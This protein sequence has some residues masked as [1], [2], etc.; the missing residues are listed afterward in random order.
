MANHNNGWVTV[1]KNLKAV[2]SDFRW[3][4]QQIANTPINVAQIVPSLPEL[5]GYMDSCKY[6]AGGVWILPT[7][8]KT[9][10]FIVWTVNFTP[11]IIKKFNTHEITINDLELAG[12]LLGWLVLEHLL[13]SLHH[14]QIGIKCDNSATVAWAR[15]FSAR[16]LRAGHLLC[17]LALRQQICSSSPLLVVHTPGVQNDMA[18]VASCFASTPKLTKASPNLLT[19]FNTHFKQKNSW[20]IF[21]LPTKLTSLVMSLLLDMQLSLESWRRLPGLVKSTGATGAVTQRA[22]TSTRYCRAPTLSSETL[23][24]QH[25]LQGSGVV[26]TAEDIRSEFKASLM[27]YRPSARPS[28]WLATKAPSTG[29]PTPTTCKSKDA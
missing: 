6:A 19:H 24:L 18:D 5:H 11:E 1:T 3:L 10:R 29:R 15:K 2:F 26:T 7:P 22:S 25:S 13:P 21:N 23:S 9:N 28:S 16:S 8:C 12:V 20:E 14:I 27:R 17:A 4:F